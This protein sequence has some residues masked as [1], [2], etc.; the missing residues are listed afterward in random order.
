MCVAHAG[1][2]RPASEAFAG[3][4]SGDI[5]C[6]QIPRLR[7]DERRPCP[8]EEKPCHTAAFLGA[9]LP[10]S[11][12]LVDD[13]CHLFR[14][15]PSTSK[16]QQNMYGTYDHN[17][18][19]A[20]TLETMRDAHLKPCLST[21]AIK[22]LACLR[23]WTCLQWKRH[24]MALTDG[25]TTMVCSVTMSHSCGPVQLRG[26]VFSQCNNNLALPDSRSRHSTASH[27]CLAALMRE[28]SVWYICTAYFTFRSSQSN[29]HI[30]LRFSTH[31]LSKCTAHLQRC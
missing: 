26:Q 13:I 30:T 18:H 19:K 29:W 25:Q 7:S 4:A 16:T 8:G 2:E 20:H 28:R 10:R 31:A 14:L 24:S 9:K 6:M 21:Q 17:Q 27:N 22:S 11:L 5:K 1:A 23:R 15:L 3:Y 12:A